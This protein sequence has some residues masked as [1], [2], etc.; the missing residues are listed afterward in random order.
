MSLDLQAKNQSFAAVSI[1]NSIN[2]LEFE[3]I[4]LGG[5]L[6]SSRNLSQTFILGKVLFGENENKKN[7]DEIE[8]VEN[9]GVEESWTLK[10]KLASAQRVSKTPSKET[11]A[12][13]I[14]T[15]DFQNET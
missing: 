8:A 5:F 4:G 12:L 11:T 13:F 14:K 3:R 10:S 2:K 1:S 7:Y 15:K 6:V 9:E